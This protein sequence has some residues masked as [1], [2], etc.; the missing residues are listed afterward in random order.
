MSSGW[1]R[2]SHRE[3]DT[4]RSTPY[5]P[6]LKHKRL[7]KLTKGE[8]VPVEVEILPASIFL[9]SGESLVLVI[10]GSE[11]I[12]EDLPAGAASRGY[13]HTETVNKGTH[14]IYTGGKY[15]SFL[16]VPVIPTKD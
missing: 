14:S 15:D 5:Q 9:S 2:V 12:I 8:I 13:G 6:V 10:K 7:L 16:L 1:L 4:E 3:L 11:I